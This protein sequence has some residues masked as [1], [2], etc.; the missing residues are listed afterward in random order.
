MVRRGRARAAGLSCSRVFDPGR[1]FSPLGLV[2]WT[3]AAHRRCAGTC[4]S[5]LLL[6]RRVDGRPLPVR[7][8]GFHRNGQWS[9]TI[10]PR[11][12]SRC[13]EHDGAWRVG[14]RHR[15]R[16][17]RTGAMDGRHFL[18]DLAG[19]SASWRPTLRKRRSAESPV[20]DCCPWIGGG[21]LA[22]TTE[23][24]RDCMFLADRMLDVAWHGHDRITNWVDSDIC[25]LLAAASQTQVRAHGGP[26][27]SALG[28]GGHL[29]RRCPGLADGQRVPDAE[30]QSVLDGSRQYWDTPPSLGCRARSPCSRALV[31]LRLA[32]DQR[33]AGSWR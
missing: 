10:R 6:G 22:Q 29:R 11:A 32:T 14:G 23:P 8:C 31:G 9:D 26:S 17:D 20:H 16:W 4:W 2:H 13:L 15:V 33:G 1:N 7:L 25:H 28:T 24:H 12:F 27:N 30:L 21:W 3:G 5:H 19:R 18:G